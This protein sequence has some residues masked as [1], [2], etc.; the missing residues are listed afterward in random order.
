[1][2]RNAIRPR[3]EQ[4][5][6]PSTW[7]GPPRSMCRIGLVRL[8]SKKNAAFT[9]ARRVLQALE[10]RAL[11]PCATGSTILCAARSATASTA[12]ARIGGTADCTCQIGYDNPRLTVSLPEN[13][14]LYWLKKKTS[15]TP[16][17]VPSFSNFLS[18]LQLWNTRD[19]AT[20]R[21][22]AE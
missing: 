19:L 20:T 5:L 10:S 18:L 22:R 13:V 21:R 3:F 4:K 15:A 17:T 12:R 1:V 14:M 6:T 8:C 9:R 2:A 16:P 7:P 11:R